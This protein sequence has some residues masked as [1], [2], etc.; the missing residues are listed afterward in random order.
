[1][2]RLRIAFLLSLTMSPVPALG[3]QTLLDRLAESRQLYEAAEYDRALAVM[4]T[5]D[6]SSISADQAAART[7]YQALCFLAL[8]L[9]P[10]AEA[11]LE[12]LVR[13]DPLF[14]PPADT[15]PRLRTLLSN[16]RARLR[17]ELAQ[18]RYA[19]GKAAFDQRNYEGAITELRLAISL[20]GDGDGGSSPTLADLRTLAGGFLELA[21]RGRAATLS[22]TNASSAPASVIPPRVI[23]QNLPPWPREL[24]P[25]FSQLSGA[26]D[27]VISSTGHV[28]SATVVR[29]IHPQYDVLL[30]AAAKQW[31]YSP[32]TR[33]GKPVAFVKRL[34]VNVN[35]K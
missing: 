10:R 8:D 25:R 11:S 5:I 20:T 34:T 16:V 27:I 12:T 35:P 19:A 23:T 21:E 3:G 18:A 6:P 33:D 22:R 30:I 15:S 14:E 26:V 24:V 4:D 7:L 1:M 2:S 17:P 13:V 31:R 28:G 9:R 29:S 32:A